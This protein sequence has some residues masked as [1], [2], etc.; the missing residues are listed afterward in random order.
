MVSLDTVLVNGGHPG[1]LITAKKGEEFNLNVIDE[2]SNQTMLLSTSIHWHGF[3]QTNNSWADGVAFVNQCPIATGDSFLYTFPTGDQ[4]GTFWYHSHLSTQYCDGLRGPLVVFLCFLRFEIR[5][6]MTLLRYDPND[7]HADL[8]DVDDDTTVITLADWYHGPASTLG[9]VP[10]LISTLING[11]GRFAG[12]PTS[13]LAV[14]SVTQGKRY[15]MRLISMACDPTGCSPSTATAYFTVIEVDSVN[16]EP[17]AVDSIQIFAGQRYSF[18]LNADQNISN[19]WIRTVANGGTAGFDNGINSAILRY[20]GADEV[21]PAT[22]QTDATAELVETDLH[23]LESMPVPGDAV[24]GGA[25]VVMDLAIS[26]DFSTFTFQING[27][28]YTPPT[29]PVLLQILSGAQS[30]TDLLP[31]GSVFTVPANSV[32]ELSIAGGS[33]GAPHP[34]HLHGHNFWVLRSAGNDTYNFDNP[35]VRDVFST[36]TSTTDNTTIRFVTDNAGPWVRSVL[37]ARFPR[38][39]LTAA[40]PPLQILHCHIDFHLELGLA[41]VFAEDTPTIADSTHPTGWDD[42]CPIYDA[43]PSDEQ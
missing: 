34:F 27:V 35:V 20:V 10:T 22:E 23:P 24:V 40:S 29:V 1:P 6:L 8:Y 9:V 14:V 18:V 7:P 12:G 32:V 17:L 26:L 33:A 16:V 36:G 25:D 2:L 15:R 13:Q 38:S 43:L 28:T 41:I 21:D 42:L 30:A 5:V 37:S 31:S 39:S 19:Y 11:L 3:F 4:A